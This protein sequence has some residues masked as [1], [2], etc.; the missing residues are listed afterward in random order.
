M[1]ASQHESEQFKRAKN[2][3]ILKRESEYLKRR[4]DTCKEF[5][6]KLQ[7]INKFDKA[8]E[9]NVKIQDDSST[10]S[11][12]EVSNVEESNVEESNAEESNVE[13]SNFEDEDFTVR[14]FKVFPIFI[15]FNFV[16]FV[17]HS[18]DG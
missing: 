13:E 15:L 9:E 7:N 11:K 14:S 10:E 3:A 17:V 16:F 18:G 5:E 6:V 4:G 12:I 1:S 2:E 8:R